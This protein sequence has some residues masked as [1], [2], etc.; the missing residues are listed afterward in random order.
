MTDKRVR[1]LWAKAAGVAVYH[2]AQG[3]RALTVHPFKDGSGY[4]CVIWRE[5]TEEDKYAS[6]AVIGG[7]RCRRRD[8]AGAI[9][10]ATKRFL[11]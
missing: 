10:E 2:A 8:E 9:I 3:E 7:G 1:R 6:D 4:L 11:R 5:M